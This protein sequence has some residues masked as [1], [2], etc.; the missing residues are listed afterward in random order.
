MSI[1]SSL[2]DSSLIVCPPVPERREAPDRVRGETR[3]GRYDT[4]LRKPSGDYDPSPHDDP[5]CLAR[6][7]DGN[8]NA[9][10]A[11]LNK[12]RGAKEVRADRLTAYL[13]CRAMR[14]PVALTLD[15]LDP[16]LDGL[17]D[18]EDGAFREIAA[19]FDSI[20]QPVLVAVLEGKGEAEVY[21]LWREVAKPAMARTDAMIAERNAQYSIPE[22]PIARLGLDRIPARSFGETRKAG[23]D[24]VQA[25]I[26]L[27]EKLVEVFPAMFE[28]VWRHASRPLVV[29]VFGRGL[30]AGMFE[31]WASQ[32]PGARFVWRDLSGV[33]HPGELRL[34]NWQHLTVSTMDRLLAPALLPDV[35]KIV[36]LD[37]DI[38]VR[39]DIAELFDIDLGDAPIAAVKDQFSQLEHLYRGDFSIMKE[40]IPVFRNAFFSGGATVGLHFNAGIMVMNLAKMRADRATER[41]LALVSAC[42]FRGQLALNL[43]ACD[44]RKPLAGEWNCIPFRAMSNDPAIVHYVGK[45]KPWQKDMPIPFKGEWQENAARAHKRK[46]ARA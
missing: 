36:F 9:A 30:D 6:D 34:E 37:V 45:I 38:L 12:Y 1:D 46:P 42:G 11:L 18:L 25:L 5:K 40:N 35:E 33:T 41:M 14:V 24:P 16:R 44:R 15:R 26:T 29:H 10:L 20:A 22:I 39:K 23:G 43:Y 32:F 2:T 17:A 21:A 7:F 3:K 4:A 31:R 27:D 8:L 19:Q 13:S 28:G